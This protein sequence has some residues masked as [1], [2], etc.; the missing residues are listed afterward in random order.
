MLAVSRISL[1]ALADF[2]ESGV[3]LYNPAAQISRLGTP[4]SLDIAL[5]VAAIIFLIAA[6]AFF[7]LSET[8]LTAASRARMHALEQEGDTKAALVNKLLSSPE[9]MIGAVLLGNTLVD[10]LAA[11]LA[12]ALA[13]RL[14]GEV[15]VVYAT[16]HSD[17]PHRHFR[18]CS[19]EDLRPCLFGQRRAVRRRR[20]CASSSSF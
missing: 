16:G 17:D 14:I 10:V 5:L 7:N 13:I 15:G 8:G 6:S 4:M 2:A 9:K 19:A 1:I 20:S 18:R 3:I 12:S 11:S